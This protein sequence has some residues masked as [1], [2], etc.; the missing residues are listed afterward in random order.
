[1]SQVPSNQT[2]LDRIEAGVA[3]LNKQVAQMQERQNSQGAK[4]EAHESHL[5]DHSQRLRDVE[6]RHAVAEATGSH[7][8]RQL[9]GRWAALGAIGMLLLG[10]ALTGLSKLGAALIGGY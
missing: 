7:K 10:A 8:H 2:Q 5:S 3:E 9:S 6:L 4:I 1:M